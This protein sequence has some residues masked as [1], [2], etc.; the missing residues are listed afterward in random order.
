ML[1]HRFEQVCYFLLWQSIVKLSL[2]QGRG[3]SCPCF[4]FPSPSKIPF[5]LLLFPL[6]L[7]FLEQLF[8]ALAHRHLLQA[9]PAVKKWEN[10][11]EVFFSWRHLSGCGGGG[12]GNNCW[13][14]KGRWLPLWSLLTCIS[15]QWL[16][17]NGLVPKTSHQGLNLSSVKMVWYFHFHK[18]YMI[19]CWFFLTRK[20]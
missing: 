7:A 18:E 1:H 2:I 9:F 11:Q 20:T 16:Y 6:P 17:V 19:Q 5:P 12:L 3:L 13:W 14:W 15:Q 4:T 10:A 8:E